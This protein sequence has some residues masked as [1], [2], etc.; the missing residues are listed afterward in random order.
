LALLDSDDDLGM[1]EKVPA[2]PDLKFENCH[3]SEEAMPT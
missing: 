3:P 2:L 1:K